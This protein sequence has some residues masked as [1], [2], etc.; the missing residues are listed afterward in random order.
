MAGRY[1]NPIPTRSHSPIDCLKIPEQIR[2][3]AVAFDITLPL[4]RIIDSVRAM[5]SPYPVAGLNRD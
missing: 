3:V 1:D 4:Y 2:T 5:P